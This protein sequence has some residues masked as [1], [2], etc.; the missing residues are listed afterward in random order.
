MN[1][2]KTIGVAEKIFVIRIA[3]CFITEA[4]EEGQNFKLP[5]DKWNSDYFPGSGDATLTAE[6]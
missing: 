4:V 6:T 1:N 2:H 5:V 3:R